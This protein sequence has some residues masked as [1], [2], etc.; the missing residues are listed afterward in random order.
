[1]PSCGSIDLR[2]VRLPA[3]DRIQQQRPEHEQ[4]Q[5]HRAH[6]DERTQEIEEG[7]R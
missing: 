2:A 1:M 3:R 4:P 5:R 7:D 6:H